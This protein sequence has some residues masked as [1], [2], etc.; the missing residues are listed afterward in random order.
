[1]THVKPLRG[2]TRVFHVKQFLPEARAFL[3]PVAEGH[4]SSAIHANLEY[5]DE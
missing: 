1:M 3:T 2:F 4:M 5:H